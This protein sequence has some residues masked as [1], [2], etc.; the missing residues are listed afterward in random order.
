MNE[1]VSDGLDAKQISHRELHHFSA[2]LD[3]AAGI[4]H[5]NTYA[6]DEIAA[7]LSKTSR[8]SIAET[9]DVAFPDGPEA[10]AEEIE[11]TATTVDRL[12]ARVKDESVRT[13]FLER[14]EAVKAY[15]RKNGFAG[16]TQR[17]TV[18]RASGA[19]RP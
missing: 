16:A 19:A 8:L 18:L 10:T 6:R 1:M 13:A 7:M 5:A 12:L 17:M 11:R 15:V 4:F 9:W 2:A 14:G 3:S